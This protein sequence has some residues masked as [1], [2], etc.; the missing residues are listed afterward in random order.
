MADRA[1]KT[2]AAILGPPCSTD[3]LVAAAHVDVPMISGSTTDPALSDDAY[4]TYMRTIAPADKYVGFAV[5][6]VARQGWR[7]LALLV[8][9]DEA[10][11]VASAAYFAVEAGRAGLE[12][13]VE[14]VLVDVRDDAAGWAATAAA[15]RRIDAAC[16]TVVVFAAWRVDVSRGAAKESEIPNFKGSDLGRFPLAL[17]DFWTSDHLSERPRSVD[18]FSGTR[19]RG[20][21]TLKRR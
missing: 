6:L 4:P 10:S 11:S 13:V 7:R 20:T 16:A 8:D 3:A 14:E 15:L 19:A 18:V 12:V 1:A 17:A 5:T 21:L 9:G 2:A